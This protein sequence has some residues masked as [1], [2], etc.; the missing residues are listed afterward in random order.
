MVG[1]RASSRE[2][3]IEVGLIKIHYMYIINSLKLFKFECI[4][5]TEIYSESFVLLLYSQILP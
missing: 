5:G 4:N 1:Y 2:E 3:G